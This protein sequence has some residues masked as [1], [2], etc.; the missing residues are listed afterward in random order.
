MRL[1]IGR[2]YAVSS[3]KAPSLEPRP[4]TYT[5][6]DARREATRPPSTATRVPRVVRG[7]IREDRGGGNRGARRTRAPHGR[8][9]S[10][11]SP[12]RSPWCQRRRARQLRTRALPASESSLTVREFLPD[13]RFEFLNLTGLNVAFRLPAAI[14][15]RLAHD[16]RVH[17]ERGRVVSPCPRRAV[18]AA[19]MPGRAR[20]AR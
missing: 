6:R 17:D 11:G 13:Q 5:R 16:W 10:R 12:S 9:V 18:A 2:V 7:G 14:G 8:S 19:P 15:R 20:S 3:I 4:A 1:A